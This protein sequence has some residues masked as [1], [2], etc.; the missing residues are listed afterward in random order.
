MSDR[1]QLENWKR[2]L[3][4]G[5]DDTTKELDKLKKEFRRERELRDLQIDR[6]TSWLG[7]EDMPE[8]VREDLEESLELLKEKNAEKEERIQWL[9]TSKRSTEF[10][11]RK[12]EEERRV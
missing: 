1:D 7:E 3:R 6:L 11:I 2:S 8:D 12:I 5:L 4:R 9:E 10:M